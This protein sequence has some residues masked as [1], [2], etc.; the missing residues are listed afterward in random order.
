[1]RRMLY[2]LLLSMEGMV[3]TWRGVGK[4]SAGT[5]YHVGWRAGHLEGMQLMCNT[6]TLHPLPR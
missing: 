3:G 2:R 5:L 6:S 1:M 4:D